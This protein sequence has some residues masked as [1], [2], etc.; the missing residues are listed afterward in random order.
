MNAFIAQSPASPDYEVY[1]HI[2]KQEVAVWQTFSGGF[3][4][5]DIPIGN[6]K[7]ALPLLAILIQSYDAIIDT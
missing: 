4:V 7:A 6:V 3:V 5:T 1:F 2:Y